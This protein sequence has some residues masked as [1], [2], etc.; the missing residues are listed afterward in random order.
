MHKENSW[1]FVFSHKVIKP[2]AIQFLK[3][4][5][6]VLEKNINVQSLN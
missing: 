6:I 4:E 5:T 1:T 2:N 3:K